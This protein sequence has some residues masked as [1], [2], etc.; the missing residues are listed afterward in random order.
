MAPFKNP[1][2]PLSFASSSRGA[3]PPRRVDLRGCGRATSSSHLAL[4]GYCQ[5]PKA[6][7]HLLPGDLRIP[8]GSIRDSIHH[9]HAIPMGCSA[10]K[11]RASTRPA[12][13]R[14]HSRSLLPECSLSELSLRGSA[15]QHRS[16]WLVLRWTIH[17]KMGHHPG[18]YSFSPKPWL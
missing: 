15:W 18:G 9:R 8:A 5:S 6:R 14:S 4:N 7:V 12:Q 2:I 17:C 11:A 3:W 10:R 16:W 13:E 1:S